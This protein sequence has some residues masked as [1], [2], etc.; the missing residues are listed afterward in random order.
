MFSFSQREKVARSAGLSRPSMV[1]EALG[2]LLE[3]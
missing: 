1:F 2:L 3:R